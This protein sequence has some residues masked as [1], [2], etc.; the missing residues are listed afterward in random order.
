M[1]PGGLHDCGIF[2]SAPKNKYIGAVKHLARGIL[3]IVTR[4]VEDSHV[5]RRFHE[6]QE[7]IALD[8]DIETTGGD[9]LSTGES[10]AQRRHSFPKKTLFG[11]QPEGTTTSPPHKAVQH[12]WAFGVRF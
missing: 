9:V 3:K 6:L 4:R 5:E 11:P 7:R 12:G 2:R 10:L 1:R 8:N